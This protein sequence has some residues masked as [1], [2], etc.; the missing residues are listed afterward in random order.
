[1]AGNAAYDWDAFDSEDYLEH[2]YA[3]LHDEDRKILNFVR[4]FLCGQSFDPETR[5]VDVGTGTNLYPAL[6]MLPFCQ[7]INLLE[8]SAANRNWLLN[9]LRHYSK[10]WDSFWQV[11]SEQEIYRTVA[12]P[13]ERL[14]R[15]TTVRKWDIL[16]PDPEQKWDL[17]TMFFVAESITSFHEEFTAAIGKFCALLR[18]GA[19]FAMTF[20]ENSSGYEVGGRPFPALRIDVTDVREEMSGLGNGLEFHRVDVGAQPLR[21]GY[22]G[23]ILVHG[24]VK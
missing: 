20:M 13:R 8:F 10:N 22:S 21:D 9:Q 2:N 12:R 17:G 16:D 23:M 18:P 3:N 6:A 7:E 5:G 24:H 4:D 19:P 15:I 14:H 11:L 1:M